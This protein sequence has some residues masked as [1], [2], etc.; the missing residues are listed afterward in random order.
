MKANYKHLKEKNDIFG[1]WFDYFR[2]NRVLKLEKHFG[3]KWFKDKEILELGCSFGNIGFHLKSLGANVTFSDANKECLKIVKSKDK[4]A[5]VILL[6]QDTK[7]ILNKKFDLIIHFGV[8]YNLNYWERD[9]ITSINHSK[10]IAL[11][12]AVTK[13]KDDTE[14]KIINYK[15]DHILH[16]P[17]NGIGTLFSGHNVQKILINNNCSFIR[18]DDSNLNIDNFLYDWK[19][20]ELSYIGNEKIINSYWNNPFFGGRRYWIINNNE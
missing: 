17:A 9:L 12:T 13:F 6:N 16:G 1:G 18:Y 15:Y 3:I 19:E 20:S 5:N 10:H 4:N 2:L 11:E 7:W 8:L 14:F